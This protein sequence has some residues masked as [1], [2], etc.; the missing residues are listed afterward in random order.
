MVMDLDAYFGNADV[1]WVIF[2]AFI[3]EGWVTI[4]CVD[5]ERHVAR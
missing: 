2:F 5:T 3:E 1:M 4:T